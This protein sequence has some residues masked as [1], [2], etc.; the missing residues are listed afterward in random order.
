[1][2]KLKVKNII[3]SKQGEDSTNY[4]EFIKLVKKHNINFIIVEAGDIINIDKNSYFQILWPTEKQIKQ[5]ILNNNS[6]VAKFVYRNTSILFTGDIEEIAE[7]QIIAKYKNTIL[8]NS[9][10]LKVAHHRF[11]EFVNPTICEFSR[12][13]D[14]FNRSRGNKYVWTS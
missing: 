5:N 7:K 8:L 2:D 1:M 11:K 3:I 14:S 6:I 10:I 9:T 4:T 12:A 13:K